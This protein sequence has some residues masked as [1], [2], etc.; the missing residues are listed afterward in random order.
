MWSPL[1]T[2]QLWNT[3]RAG[4]FGV[5]K[6]LNAE[7]LNVNVAMQGL[8]WTSVKSRAGWGFCTSSSFQLLVLQS[9]GV[10]STFLDLFSGGK[11]MSVAG[12]S[13]AAL[14]R[15]TDK[16]QKHKVFL[17]CVSHPW[18]VPQVWEDQFTLCVSHGAS[19]AK[20]HL[21]RQHL[22]RQR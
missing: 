13:L 20:Q 3:D 22:A 10:F 8:Q 1:W 15:L 19:P 16:G 12:T 7:V 18:M 4:N 11:S 2:I 17:F 6:L 21:A 5:Q 14:T 9:K